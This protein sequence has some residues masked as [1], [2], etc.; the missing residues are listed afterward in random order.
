M[1]GLGG[2]GGGG[3]HVFFAVCVLPPSNIFSYFMARDLVVPTT[4]NI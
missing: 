3:G 1:E 2:G 4:F